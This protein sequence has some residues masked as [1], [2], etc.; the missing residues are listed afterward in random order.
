MILA[1]LSGCKKDPVKEV[2]VVKTLAVNVVTTLNAIVSVGGGGEVTSDGNST[3]LSRGV[4]WS[5]KQNPTTK[6]KDSLTVDGVGLGLFDS[7]ITGLKPGTTYYIRAYATNSVGTGYGNEVNAAVS[8]VMPTLTTSLLTILSD[9]IVSGGGII[10]SDGGS[11]ITAR[12]VCWSVNKLPTIADSQTS[13]G[14]GSGSFSSLV[15]GF[16]PNSTYYLRA[17]ATNSIGTSYGAEIS[18]STGKSVV[19]DKSGNF[20]HFV[21][22]G[23][24][25]WMVEN[26]RTARYRDSTSIPHVDSNSDWNNSVNPGYCWYANDSSLYK[27]SFGALYNWYAVNTKKLCPTGWH[28]PSD[29]EWTTLSDK[30][31]GES[32]AG[33]KLKEAGIIT[34]KNPNAAATNETGFTGLPGGFRT[35]PGEFD[36]VGSYGNWWSS[37]AVNTTVANYRYLYFGNGI[38]TKSFIS[39]KY[40]LSVRCLKD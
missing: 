18:F 10:Q 12:G 14:T 3:I 22:I 5:V 15:T 7:S 19:K 35:A 25:V 21:T 28:V 16:S 8:A 30:L 24:Q 2:P 23:S 1:F 4:C 32:L 38:M 17:Y 40:G 39:Q 31:G 36:Q 26:L 13:N 11:Q 27:N 33:G 29:A 9:S 34:W 6:S 37:T 20:Y